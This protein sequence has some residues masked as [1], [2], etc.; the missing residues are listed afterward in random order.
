MEKANQGLF[1]DYAVAANQAK[2]VIIM[3]ISS[4]ERV[5]T[6]IKHKL[7]DRAPVFSS[8]TP[9]LAD[10]LRKELDI[11]EEDL[12][13]ALGNDM[14][15]VG[16]GFERSTNYSGESQYIC[17]W[18]ITWKNV[19][20]S[21]GYYTEVVKNPLSGDESKLDTWDIPDP[22]KDPQYDVMKRMIDKYGKDYWIAGSARQTLF[23][24]AW[25]LRGMDEF[26]T[27]LLT[28]EEY[29]NALLDKIIE[30]PR[31]ALKEFIRMGA[32]MIWVGDDVATQLAMMISPVTWRKFFKP[33]YAKLFKEFRKLNPD[34]V[35][36]YHSCGNCHD[37]IDELIEIGM[38][39]LHPLQ[40]QAIDPVA[41]KK[42]FGN[43]LAL[44][45]ALD[46]QL[47]MPNGSPEDVREETLR[48]IKGCGE[49]GGYI[50]GGAHHFQEDTPTEN[51]LALYKTIKEDGAY[52]KITFGSVVSTQEAFA[53]LR[54]K[55]QS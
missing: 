25:N 37:V 13:V 11:T 33:R 43:R 48:L 1:F 42:E 40:P 18:G 5:K 45:G 24:A 35:I 39:V 44:L 22:T 26:L 17:P 50:L 16:I 29:V 34:I 8:F 9:R 19:K 4:K 15:Q 30:Y 20:N 14:I 27:D 36:A 54:A 51:I 2:G 3:A 41:T 55:L 23:E 12:G 31:Y 21:F 47:L 10:K 6:T 32:D 49:G 7:P 38:D 28:N 53:K 52:D 46:I